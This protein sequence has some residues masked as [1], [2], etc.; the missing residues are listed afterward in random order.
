MSAKSSTVHTGSGTEGQFL[1]DL[2]EKMEVKTLFNLNIPCY[3]VLDLFLLVFFSD[4]FT[5]LQVARVQ[6]QI[7]E[8]LN[9]LDVNQPAIKEGMAR[10]DSNL[11]DITTV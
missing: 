4:W 6:L 10:L 5:F 11:L 9:R 8:S 2:E 7:Y 1:H 3:I